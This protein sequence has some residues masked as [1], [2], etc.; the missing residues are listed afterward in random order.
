[1][2]A[3]EVGGKPRSFQKLREESVSRRWGSIV[4]RPNIDRKE[5]TGVG[6]MEV[7]MGLDGRS[8]SRVAMVGDRVEDLGCPKQ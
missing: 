8:F 4:E 1:M 5:L 7:I 2:M 6:D 3:S